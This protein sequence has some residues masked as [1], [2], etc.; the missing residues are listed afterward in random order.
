MGDS[1]HP[2]AAVGRNEEALGGDKEN[3]CTQVG[4]FGGNRFEDTKRAQRRGDGRWEEP[5]HVGRN[6]GVAR[7]EGTRQEER[8]AVA[9]VALAQ[10]FSGEPE[11]REEQMES[12]QGEMIEEKLLRISG[13]SKK[14]TQQGEGLGR[15][16]AQ[17]EK[18][19][20]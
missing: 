2:E 17:G 3:G 11:G 15:G 1:V 5:V 10:V 9:A 8:E 4:G 20:H 13:L 12:G 18:D 7:D 14:L 16:G 6:G 19:V